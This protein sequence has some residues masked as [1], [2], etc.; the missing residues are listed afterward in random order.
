MPRLP[1]KHFHDAK[2]A[3]VELL[4]FCKGVSE[5][6]FSTRR[7][8]QL[9]AERELEIIGEAFSRLRREFQAEADAIPE[10][11][12]IIGLRNIIA[13]GYD[14]VDHLILWDVIQNHLPPLLSLIEKKLDA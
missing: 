5:A 1:E 12:R 3:V 8:L 14:V 13:H 7:D 6:D 11:N 10:L 4:S 2:L 9:I